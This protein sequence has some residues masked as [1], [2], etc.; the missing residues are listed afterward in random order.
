MTVAPLVKRGAPRLAMALNWRTESYSKR[1]ESK[2]LHLRI[3]SVRHGSELPQF[4]GSLL[5][6]NGPLSAEGEF[7]MGTPAGGGLIRRQPPH[8]RANERPEG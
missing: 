4:A 8:L 1:N 7:A 6:P 3:N 2:V 5:D